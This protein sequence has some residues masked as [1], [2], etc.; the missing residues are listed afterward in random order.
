MNGFKRLLAM[1][2]SVGLFFNLGC[3]TSSSKSAGSDAA[4]LGNLD[5]LP[6][7]TLS[8]LD[9]ADGSV[10]LPQDS[11]VDAGDVGDDLFATTSPPEELAM[12]T[13]SAPA[14]LPA[15]MPNEIVTE[16]PRP[17]PTQSLASSVEI[18][19]LNYKAH[20]NGG[21]LV[22]GGTSPLRYQT[23]INAGLNQFIIEIPGGIVPARLQRPLVTKDIPGSF[24]AVQAFSSSSDQPAQ[25]IVQLRPGSAEPMVQAE[26]KNLLVIS[27]PNEGAMAGL[28]LET[29]AARAKESSSKDPAGQ[30][31][32]S[33]NL[34]EFLRSNSRFYGR[35][36]SIEV[37]DIELRDVFKLIGE[38]AGINLIIAEDVRGKLSLKL[39]EVPWDQALVLIL[40]SKRLGYTR[41][42]NVLRIAS[43]NEIRQEEDDSVKALA[44]AKDLAPLRVKLIPISYAPIVDIEK[45]V[46]AF[47]SKRGSVAGDSRTSAII[48]SDIDEVIERVQKLVQSIDIPP[49]QVLIEGKIVEA[50][51]QFERRFGIQWNMT[52]KRVPVGSQNMLGSLNVSPAIGQG[53]TMSFNFNFGSLDVLGD[54]NA[55]LSLY[56][57]EG[58]VK[59]LSSPRIM[60]LHN[61]QALIS[62]S[63]AVPVVT[64]AP[65]P[66][67]VSVPQV[68]Y[69]DAKLQL[70]VTP[71]V[72]N[73]GSVIMALDVN[74]DAVGEID[75]VSSQ[76][77]IAGR[78][79][80]TKVLIRN[81]QT[82]VIGGI[83]Q[84][85]STETENRVPGL[86]NLPVVG[87]MF[88]SKTRDS[89]KNELLIFLTPR[90][91]AQ[92]SPGLE[93]K[94]GEL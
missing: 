43:L 46:K 80:K 16:S 92:A 47:L 65:G 54:L 10:A 90:V 9:T 71:Q 68:T 25:I 11:S 14:E 81:G 72:T 73:D 40:K 86:G 57:R 2:L 41:S 30:L 31:L 45:Q 84:N 39:R 52:G 15:E 62:Q 35:K 55:A 4:R 64:N 27:Q 69:R 34:E 60:A 23:R 59:I 7:D 21:T 29:G 24:G 91:I 33:G 77:P 67:G 1:V 17:A 37:D 18:T 32:S 42:G 38:E 79:A 74:R 26:G 70:S 49:T 85:E 76:R 19:S 93:L 53:G 82:A 5:D 12:D 8:P 88:K 83:Y 87:W 66:N 50:S 20:Q 28:N 78:S 51:D 63:L 44:A 48:V 6:E 75:P 56:E 89:R 36:I 58:S 61:E 94:K 13:S 22:I 3:A